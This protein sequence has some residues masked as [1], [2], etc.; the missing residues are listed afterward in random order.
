[1]K[2]VKKIFIYSIIFFIFIWILD[3]IKCEINTYKLKDELINVEDGPIDIKK[4]KV[5]YCNSSY[6]YVYWCCDELGHTISYIK[7]DKGEWQLYSWDI[8]VWSHSG[9]ADDFIWPYIR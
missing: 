5:L 1:M 9:S 8:A 6:A 3:I 7:D 4:F 2:I